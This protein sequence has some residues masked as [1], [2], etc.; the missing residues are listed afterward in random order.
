MCLGKSLQDGYPRHPP[1][2]PPGIGD[3]PT[4][5]NTKLSRQNAKRGCQN[6]TLEW[7]W[8]G[9]GNSTTFQIAQ[10]RSN[11]S[12]CCFYTEVCISFPLLIAVSY[13][14]HLL[15]ACCAEEKG[16]LYSEAEPIKGPRNW[17]PALSRLHSIL[18]ATSLRRTVYT[19]T[20]SV[21]TA[22]LEL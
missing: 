13:C 7:E 19:R 11:I 9:G 6:G 2:T 3:S 14:A 17:S 4:W 8:G 12:R 15:S 5:R 16:V 1:P 22:H 10:Q 18:Q 21:T 20:K